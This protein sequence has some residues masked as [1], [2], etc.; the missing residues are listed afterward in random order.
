MKFKL[1]SMAFLIAANPAH[2]DVIVT[3]DPLDANYAGGITGIAGSPQAGTT[4][5]NGLT[6]NITFTPTADDLTG[7]VTLME[8]GGQTNGVA[9]YLLDGV[10]VVLSKTAGGGVYTIPDTTFDTT[11][12]A[13][14]H[15]GGSLS[16]AVQTTVALIYDP[17]SG[18]LSLAVGSTPVTDTFSITSPQL[19]WNGNNSLSVGL[20]SVNAG[21]RA[22]TFVA[23]GTFNQDL[24]SLAGTIDG[25]AYYWN[26]SEGSVITPSTD[27]TTWIAGNFANGSVIN[28]DPGDD[29][30]NDGIINLLEY[31]IA[32]EDPTVPNASVGSFTGTSLS[33]TKR[34]D[35]VGLTYAIEES[36][37]LGATD[38]WAEVS[39]DSYV[40]DANTISYGF[41]P[42]TPAMNY[43]RLE[44]TR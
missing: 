39:G 35:A 27:F 25:D 23:A 40:N 21:D 41:T 3:L 8:I 44:V 36:T 15:S 28:Q 18:D 42:G 13:V 32:G 1:L 5:E 33:F 17:V 37:D 9:M 22:G 16:A 19:N 4:Q 14:A 24:K 34:G 11:G 6:F 20:R 43:L 12:I 26:S 31:A 10:P 29:D 30:D 38:D 2:A 7:L